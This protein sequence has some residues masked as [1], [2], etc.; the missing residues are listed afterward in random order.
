MRVSDAL[1]KAQRE[2]RVALVAYLTAG[3]PDLAATRVF[4]TEMARAGADVI[5]LGVPFSDPVADGPTN[6]RASE[7]ALKSK[8]TLAGIFSMCRGLRADGV[9][10]PLVLFT[11]FNP[12]F[13][14]G[15]VAFADQA[16]S[17]G[18]DAALIVDLPPEEAGEFAEAL[19]QKKIGTIFLASPTT[20]EKRLKAI[21]AASSEFVYYVSRTGVTGVQRAL[22]EDLIVKLKW[23]RAHVSNPLCVGFGISTAEQ[24]AFLAN[25][26][27]VDGVIVG[28]VLVDM[29]ASS[30]T[31]EIAA[32]GLSDLVRSF[33]TVL[34]K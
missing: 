19:R 17:A 32:K 24:A 15:L 9:N 23:V 29:I 14:L 3:D 22:S 2:N 28:S 12:V 26:P 8:T 25:C 33:K 11:Y 4:V 1:E 21:D 18:V 30:P 16:A 10:V 27:E 31:V 34:K 20:D 7:R 6:L 5:E 13:Q